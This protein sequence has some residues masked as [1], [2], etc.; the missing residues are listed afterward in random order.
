MQLCTVIFISSPDTIF[1]FKNQQQHFG[2]KCKWLEKEVFP[3]PWSIAISAKTTSDTAQ[4]LKPFPVT[5]CWLQ[6][7]YKIIHI[8]HNS[9]IIFC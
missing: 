6:M 9:Y 5:L 3:A 1:T 7:R 4:H 8:H 2:L